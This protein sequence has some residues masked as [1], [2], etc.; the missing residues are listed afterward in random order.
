MNNINP[1]LEMEQRH[2]DALARYPNLCA[3]GILSKREKGE[4]VDP[5]DIA[6]ALSFLARC[7]RTKRPAAHTVDLRR[8][9]SRWAGRPIS[10]GAVIAGAVGAGFEAHGW[11]G[12][13]E[14]YP[15]ALVNVRI[16]DVKAAVE[17]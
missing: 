12:V 17:G 5:A 6:V 11:Y 10:T 15:N 4:P 13:M 3:Q 7:R 8:H 1:V 9:I 2:I 16:R 14:Y